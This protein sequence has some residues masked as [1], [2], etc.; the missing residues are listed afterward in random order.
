MRADHRQISFEAPCLIIVPAGM[1]HGFAWTSDSTGS[2][3]TVSS[4]YLGRLTE[5]DEAIGALFH[6][7]GV[8]TLDGEGSDTFGSATTTLMEELA[9][10]LPGH[11]AAVEA[12]LLGLCV[13]AVR[14]R[15]LG[16][17]GD[18]HPMR[19]SQI[20]LVA[21]LRERI[22]ACFRLREPIAG[23]AIA[24]NAS[25]TRLREACAR[26][27][28]QSPMQMLDERAMLE[29]QRALLYS[30]LSVAQ[31]AETLGFADAAY[32][33]RFFSRHAGMPPRAYRDRIS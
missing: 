24:L 29:A 18:D 6:L 28:G 9:W 30:N 12:L 2:V 15:G 17:E 5:C 14:A 25:E 8:A 32:F 7:V 20:A 4:A 21:R 16:E 3:I 31:I 33:S 23:Y 19:G 10:S 22:E 11:H 13:R 1:V 27:A 26:I